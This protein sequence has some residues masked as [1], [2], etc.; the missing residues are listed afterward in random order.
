MAIELL[1][2]LAA[3]KLGDGLHS[4]GGGLF[5]KVAG[6]SAVWTFRYTSPSGKRREMGLGVANRSTVALATKSLEDARRAAAE[7]RDQIK[8]GKDPIDERD[9]QKSAQRAADAAKKAAAKVAELTLARAARAYHGRVIEPNRTAKHAR[10]WIGSLE[11]HVPKTLWHAPIATITAPVL[12]DCIADLQAKVPETASRVRQRLEAIFDDCEFRGLSTGNPARAIR[13]KLREN[14]R[15]RDRGHFAALDYP[16]APEFMRL[17]RARPAIAARA[18]EFAV[19]TAARTGEVIG[20]TWDE[21][22]LQ[23][24]V[25]TLPAKRTKAGEVHVVYL[26]APALAIAKSMLELNQPYVFPSPELDG[27]PLSNMAMLTLLR[28]MDADK[29]TT[30]HGLA[31]ATFSTWA[32][33][34]NMAR[35]DVIEACLAHQEEDRVKSA[36]NRAQFN[37][38][39]KALLAA[40]AAYLGSAAPIEAANDAGTAG[41]KAA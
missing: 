23:A 17:I 2:P 18:L 9:A 26:S 14:K 30:V 5:L 20:A 3:H 40:W 19:L 32:Y 24:G 38:E 6:P 33:D 34:L 29:V 10:E 37:A 15:G 13:R 11:N 35:P 22:D 1:K 27:K 4:D 39:R 16:K 25:W 36:Y 41:R 31:R 21:F 8:R 28:R 12:L 7:A